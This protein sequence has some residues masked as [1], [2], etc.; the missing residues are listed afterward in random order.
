[1]TMTHDVLPPICRVKISMRL[2]HRGKLGL[3]GLC[4]QLAR[5]LA[6][7]FGQRIVA[8]RWLP[9]DGDYGRPWRIAS[10]EELAHRH[11]TPPPFRPPLPTFP[12]GSIWS[13]AGVCL[14]S[15]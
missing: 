11:D 2:D 3:D 13:H 1:M 14:A 7:D 9:L 4:R 10:S 12:H 8:F 15:G 6:Q 5:S